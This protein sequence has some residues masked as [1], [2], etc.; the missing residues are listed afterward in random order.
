MPGPAPKRS[1]QRRR[2]NA[3]AAEPTKVVGA[4]DAP[5]LGFRAHKLVTSLYK[6]LRESI[7]GQYFSAADWQRARIELHYLNELLM[8]D[9]VP[10]AQAWS[11]VQAGL[12]ALLVS[13]ADK[14][15][16]GIEVQRA[17]ADEDAEAAVAV[18]ADW[19]GKLG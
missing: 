9:R 15:R 13:P 16:I 10:G 14:R 1:D 11:A 2:R 7:E 18:M 17:V 6:A 19:R 8:S 12:S 3:P 5:P 4:V